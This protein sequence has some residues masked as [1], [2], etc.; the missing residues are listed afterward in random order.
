MAETNKKP[1]E[2]QEREESNAKRRAR[3]SK[4][5]SAIKEVVEQVDSL[6]PMKIETDQKPKGEK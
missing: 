3:R 6:Q 4:I 1:R 5:R 2:V